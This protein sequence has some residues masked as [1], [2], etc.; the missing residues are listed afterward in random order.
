LRCE[1]FPPV[2]YGRPKKPVADFPTDPFAPIDIH[3]GHWRQD[4]RNQD[5]E[6]QI[7]HAMSA[8]PLTNLA[9]WASLIIAS[10]AITVV[11]WTALLRL[12]GKV[13][14]VHDMRFLN[15]WRPLLLETIDAVPAHLPRVRNAD[16][17]VFLALWN[18]L[19]DSVKGPA[20]HRLKAVALRLRMDSAARSLLGTRDTDNK[21]VGVMTLGHLGDQDSWGVLE[22]IARSRTPVLSMAALRALFLIDTP[23]AMAILL[24]ALGARNDWPAAQL[25][26]VLAEVDS[27]PVAEGLLQAAEIAIPSELPRIIALMDAVD[28]PAVTSYLDQLIRTSKDEEVLIAC[29]KSRHVTSD[30]DILTPFMKSTSWQIRTQIARLLG[31]CI[32]R[33]QEQ[34][35]ISLLSDEV[36]WVRYRAA[37]SL[38]QLPFFSHDELWRLRFLLNDRFAQEILDQVVAERRTQ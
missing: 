6:S 27:P 33:G 14:G 28:S 19:H 34:L 37:Q 5:Q 31:T 30:L 12:H 17:F 2:H 29:L 18:Q 24:S 22:S 25:T 35:L 10:M 26:T 23:R 15:R 20:K 9:L 8:D 36:W 13:L 11:I 4:F 38:A 7:L 21:L 3:A 16:W 1:P 32:S